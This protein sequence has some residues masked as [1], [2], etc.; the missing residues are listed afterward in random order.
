MANQMRLKAIHGLKSGD[1]FMYQRTF[2]KEETLIF[3]DI[4]RDYNPIHYDERWTE[5]KGFKGPICH[6]L[7]VGSMICEFGG[8]VG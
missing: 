3:G 1:T 2:T 6:G 4:T 7:L 8:Q 5:Q